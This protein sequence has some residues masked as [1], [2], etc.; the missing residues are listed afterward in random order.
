MEII[1]FS[2]SEIMHILNLIASV[3]K[4]GNVQFIPKA[5]MDGTEGCSLMNEYGNSLSLIIKSDH[6]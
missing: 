6:L 1:G 2:E 5:N 3:L 4:L